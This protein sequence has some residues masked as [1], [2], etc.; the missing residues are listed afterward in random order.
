MRNNLL[1]F[2]A[3]ALVFIG[4]RAISPAV[5]SQGEN[6][7]PP[8]EEEI[9]QI[10]Y[11]VFGA[12]QDT[13]FSVYSRLGSLTAE[14][15]A[16]RITDRI[17][18]LARNDRYVSDSLKVEE[19]E[20]GYD[21]L[22]GNEI[23]GTVSPGDIR[24]DKYTIHTLAEAVRDV[25]DQ[26]ILNYKEETRMEAWLKRIALAVL[27][28]LVAGLIFLLVQKGTARFIT[29]V[30]TR[31]LGLFKD[32]SYKGY[33][34]LTGEKELVLVIRAVKILKWIFLVILLYLSLP[35][36]FS[37]FPFSRDWSDDILDWVLTPIGKIFES[38]LEY[39]PN[40]FS[41]LV[42]IF[43][44]R[45][46]IKFIK[47]IF[48]E[49]ESERLAVS[50]FHP[51]WAMPT[52]N[53]VRFLL[54][55]FTLVLIFPYLPG[56]DSPIFKGVS[57]FIGV[58]FSLGSS[59]AI[60][61]MIAGL[62]ITYMR[63]FKP[64][65]RIKIADV[66]GDVIEKTILVTRIRTPKNEI[67][68]IPNSSVLTGNTINYSLQAEQQGLILFT[69][70]TLGY[71]IPWRKI[72]ETLIEAALATKFVE[73]DPKPYVLQTS[74]DDFY[75]TYQLNAFTKEASKQAMIYSELHQNIQDF[76]QK[77]GIE[78]MSPHYR[79]NRDGSATTIPSSGEEK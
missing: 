59:S 15:R 24:N 51:D 52:Y 56:S 48:K 68:T 79:A 6:S 49:I 29:W 46:L 78:I 31:K 16:R 20:N 3:F 60:T 71:D 54:F 57:V 35:V 74:L 22:Y 33:T 4:V 19:L 5:A 9:K 28:I 40:L 44:M 27:T 70:V 36:L 41:I 66:S 62:V 13:L 11:P 21:I 53:I 58:I 30:S 17:Q 12:F 55:A 65:D 32:L 25:I 39:L 72:H 8:Q 64:G 77:N 37:I 63:P 45:Y 26:D 61:N 1:R 67:I 2:L 18:N 23:I 14:E 47:F 43:F 10:G 7:N 50:G 73:K 42:I 76:C 34:F 75:V 69:S 38:T